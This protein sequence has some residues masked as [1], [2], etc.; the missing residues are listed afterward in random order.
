MADTY[1]IQ[2]QQKIG[3]IYGRMPDATKDG[4]IGNFIS[5]ANNWVTAYTGTASGASLVYDDV[6]TDR[7]GWRCVVWMAGGNISGIGYTLGKLKMND[8]NSDGGEGFANMANLLHM[9]MTEG[10]QILGK[11]IRYDKVND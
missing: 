3:E 2:V 5:G 7:A 1:D 11:K 4:I 8:P 6:V 10:L 9:G